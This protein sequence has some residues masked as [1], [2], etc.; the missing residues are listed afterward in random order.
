[1]NMTWTCR[2]LEYH[3]FQEIF[4]YYFNT[5][6][7]CQCVCVCC[8][9]VCVFLFY[10]FGLSALST[11]VLLFALLEMPNAPCIISTHRT[12]TH[13]HRAHI[14]THTHRAHGRWDEIPRNT[15]VFSVTLREI[16][17]LRSYL[18]SVA[19]QNK[20]QLCRAFLSI[21][22]FVLRES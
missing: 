22:A 3:K 8:V 19:G 18:R 10:W 15:D 21:S 7:M 2:C 20:R 9:C 17:Y 14:H 6:W 16:H 13:T 5:T 12:H 1:M 4:M 11:A